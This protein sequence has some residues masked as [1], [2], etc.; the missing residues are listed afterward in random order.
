MTNKRISQLVASFALTLGVCISA[1]A[2]EIK[3][4]SLRFQET[5][6]ENLQKLAILPE[7]KGDNA[8][9]SNSR[10]HNPPTP[11]PTPSPSPTPT[12]SKITDSSGN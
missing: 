10:D 3:P 2:S 5:A 1:E 4:A 11:T 8:D 7:P 12:P 9:H 6:I